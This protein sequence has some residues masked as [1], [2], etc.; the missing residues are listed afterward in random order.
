MSERPG[1][2]VDDAARSLW[3]LLSV[4]AP[5]RLVLTGPDGPIL[6][7]TLAWARHS[8]GTTLVRRDDAAGIAGA[9]DLLVCEHAGLL[10]PAGP[11]GFSALIPAGEVPL[12]RERGWTARPEPAGAAVLLS[13]GDAPS[14][15][16]LRLESYARAR[17]A[18]SRELTRLGGSGAPLLEVSPP[19]RGRVETQAMPAGAAATAR[20]DA[21][22]NGAGVFRGADRIS[23]IVPVHNAAPELRR[24]LYSLARHTTGP[25]ELLLIDD[26]S[27]DPEVAEIL[28]EAAELSEV[29]VLVNAVN[30]G[31]TATVNRGLRASGGDVVLLNS[32]TEV[33]PRWLERLTRVARSR[34]GVATVTP[35]SDNAGAFA[36]PSTGEANATPLAL[37]VAGVARG[38]AQAAGPPAST[39]TGSGFCL[40][41]TRAAIDAVGLF[42]ADG[43]PR[44]YGEENDFCMRALRAGWIHLVD[45]RTFVHH[46]REA[47]FGHERSE[48]AHLARRRIDTR[49]PEYTGLVR[50]FVTSPGLTDVR[51]RVRTA[52]AQ[53]RIPRPRVLTVIHEGGGGTWTANLELVRALELEWDPLVLTSDRRTVRLWQMRD[54]ELRQVREW[55]LERSIRVTD[56]SRQ[57]YAEIVREVLDH[58]EVEL[59]HVR[60]LFK[61]TFDA[62][63]IAAR[64][65]IPVVFSFHDF[66]FACPT[67]NLLDDR[68]HYCGGECTPGNGVCRVPGAGLEGLPHLKH[69]YV[70]QWRQEA[71]GMLREV[72]AFVT[73]SEHARD[74]HLRAMSSLRGRPFELIEH[75]RTLRQRVGIAVPPEPGGP[76]RIMV[77]ANLDVHKGAD[78]VRALLAADDRGRL[79]FHLL[80]TVPDEYA[81][82]GV[83]HG[84][85]A[86]GTLPELAARIA[87]AFA[88][89]FSITPETYSHALTEAWAMGVPVLATDLGALGERIRAHGGGRLVPI[90]DPAEAVR[91]IYA[92]ADEPER[93]LRL[94]E[95]AS[96]RGCA[97]VA[98]MT[99]AYAALYR[100]VLDGRRPFVAAPGSI[101]APQ[102][103]RGVGRL[104]AVVPGADG[105]HPGSTYVRVIQRYRH[106]GVSPK[107]S[108]GV[109][110]ADEAPLAGD[111]DL[112]LVQR[113]ALR[114]DQTEEFVA[115]LAGRGTPLV[116]DFDDHLLIRPDDDLDYAPHRDSLALLIEAAAL[117]LVSTEPLRE[118]LQ[119]R[120][121]ATAVVPNMLDERLFL[122]G[123]ESRPRAGEGSG[124]RGRPD[125]SARPT[126]VVYIGSPT[127]GQDLAML[128][129]V[130]EELSRL[131]PGGAELNVVGGEAAGPGQEWYRR[132]VVP[133][134]CKPY[135]RFVGWLRE[136]RAGWD[137][138]VAPLRDDAFNR[139]KSDLKYLEYAAL[140][141]PAVY[142]DLQPYATVDGG[143]TGLKA[144]GTTE[145]WVEA[146]AR[147][148]QDAGERDQM[149]EHA[150]RE[151][152]SHRLLRHGTDDLLRL[153]TPMMSR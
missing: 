143:R 19:A 96:L 110:R 66:Y 72:D 58:W 104:L 105:V 20:A 61:H 95:Q 117:V 60:H 106:P 92:V 83:R 137:I 87:P 130:V 108:L 141:L 150:F 82:L 2:P 86:S 89:C 53:P 30:L 112:V 8:P 4:L 79:E 16:E 1:A 152:T 6:R 35:V 51:E 149:A 38:I 94:R 62:P 25:S 101:A 40:Y 74:V 49:Y 22:A 24:C 48:L 42:D 65:G 126:Q 28:A 124:R 91:R 12:A 98:D 69:G 111:P 17:L 56:Y 102:L 139:Y 123:V 57:D 138:A 142:S 134:H 54:G 127:H 88:G 23:I 13:P 10:P 70:H 81:D 135:P 146:I 115:T 43:F 73:T 7:A 76:I 132:V 45:G 109:R 99:D 151:V 15:L 11:D 84:A 80:G 68:D 128:R 114:P 63:R 133:D 136:Q 90:G 3:I 144:A 36:V 34:H 77:V 85:F 55:T 37:D 97:T 67:V 153:L 29:R 129:P 26:A 75:G 41:V 5:R 31:F 59:V 140:G 39:P 100:R 14:G 107:L 119:G 9:G 21:R 148:A 27:T 145:A 131:I 64:L 52:Y 44:G 50:E 18:M 122:L 125:G 103:A 32:D 121:R 46:V 118:A 120:A 71:E 113:T 116:L 93:Y 147:L 78:Y 47:S 33:G